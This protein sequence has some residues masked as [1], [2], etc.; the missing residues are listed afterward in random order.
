MNEILDLDIRKN[1]V[2][3]KEP[4]GRCDQI[5]TSIYYYFLKV[6][7]TNFNAALTGPLNIQGNKRIRSRILRAILVLELFQHPEY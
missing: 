2:S 4:T 6:V 3:L 7:I 5:Q 1:R